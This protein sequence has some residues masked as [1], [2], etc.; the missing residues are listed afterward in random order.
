MGPVFYVCV[1]VFV[2][3]V[4]YMCVVAFR[5]VPNLQ[6]NGPVRS[7]SVDFLIAWQRGRSAA[8]CRVSRGAMPPHRVE[9]APRKAPHRHGPQ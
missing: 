4:F 2:D 3:C 5:A 1:C 8:A 9:L 7:V 6:R